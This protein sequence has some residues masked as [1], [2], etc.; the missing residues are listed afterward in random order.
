MGF[1]EFGF[2]GIIPTPPENLK[3]FAGLIPMPTPGLIPPDPEPDNEQSSPII[4]FWQLPGAN[5]GKV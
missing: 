4:V 1:L 5:P 2:A 3:A